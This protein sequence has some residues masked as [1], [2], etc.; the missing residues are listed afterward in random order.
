MSLT[1]TGRSRDISRVNAA[2]N[3]VGFPAAAR[4]LSAGS[5]S[6]LVVQLGAGFDKN[7][8]YSIKSVTYSN[9]KWLVVCSVHAD[10]VVRDGLGSCDN[11]TGN[12]LETAERRA[13]E[14]AVAKFPGG[15]D[16]P[17]EVEEEVRRIVSDDSAQA[18]SL[19]N[20]V[21][22][23]Q[24]SAARALGDRADLDVDA[25]SE[26]M[27]GCR[28]GELS[29]EAAAV[30]IRFLRKGLPHRATEMRLAG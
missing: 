6:E 3:I 24:L 20:L 25:E 8:S 1:N 22:P 7:F 18:T 4:P 15:S 30:L 17:G 9:G 21:S 13:F 16:Q 23:S 27:F 14:D 10:G 5:E 26:R 28:L 11:G 12:A 19:L 2:F 29:R